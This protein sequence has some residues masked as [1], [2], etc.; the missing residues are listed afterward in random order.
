MTSNKALQPMRPSTCGRR[1]LQPSSLVRPT[2]AR[3]R[4]YRR[5]VLPMGYRP[6]LET[7]GGTP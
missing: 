3:H 4:R 6:S 5:P 2:D 7:L 1:V